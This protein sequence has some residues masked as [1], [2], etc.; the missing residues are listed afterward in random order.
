M[1][2]GWFRMWVPG[3]NRF[4]APG[5]QPFF[6]GQELLFPIHVAAK[7]PRK[8]CGKKGRER[9]L[10]LAADTPVYPGGAVVFHSPLALSLAELF[11]KAM[12]REMLVN[13]SV[14]KTWGL[15][16]IEEPKTQGVIDF[17]WFWIVYKLLAYPIRYPILARLAH[18]THIHMEKYL[19]GSRLILS[20]R[21]R[22][23]ILMISCILEDGNRTGVPFAIGS[24]RFICQNKC[25]TETN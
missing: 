25:P 19:P 9:W 10:T 22:W 12:E 23:D 20:W 2:W 7:E 17:G 15:V 16:K 6:Y 21:N 5:T 3:S 14:T 4:R 11:E 8:S 1:T 18:I 13:A 24:P